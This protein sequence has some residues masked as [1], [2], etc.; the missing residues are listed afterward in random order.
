[1]ALQYL[2]H[3]KSSRR[4]WVDN[5]CI[6]QASS[7]ERAAQ[8]SIMRQIYSAAHTTIAWLGGPSKTIEDAL[9]LKCDLVEIIDPGESRSHRWQPHEP[10]QPF[11]VP[12]VWDRV[13]AKAFGSGLKHTMMQPYFSQAWVLQETAVSS[14]VLLQCG[15]T[16]TRLPSFLW[17]FG[18]YCN[19]RGQGG[20]FRNKAGED[21]CFERAHRFELLHDFDFERFSL[22][23]SFCL[24]CFRRFRV[25]RPLD[26]LFAMYGL[27]ARE[28]DVLDLY[29]DYTAEPEVVYVDVAFKMLS[30]LGDVSVL[31]VPRG[32]SEPRPKL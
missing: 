12:D 4:L 1:M 14:N 28:V 19:L 9:L 30:C 32:N 24:S 22:S 13:Y 25:G 3:K 15:R 6:T 18:E 2:R 23:L 20:T 27:A 16:T 21:S 8:V 31:E 26:K 17:A 10:A 5:V 7:E 29:P 11:G